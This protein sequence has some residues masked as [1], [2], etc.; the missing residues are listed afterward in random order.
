MGSAIWSMQEGATLVIVREIVPESLLKTMVEQHIE[1]ALLVPAVMLYLCEL[2]QSKTADFSALK[3]ITYGTAPISAEVLRRSI[4]TFKCR[5][6][7]LYGL[8]ETTGPFA[9]LTHEHH[10]AEKLASCGRPMFGAR[11]KV[12]DSSGKELPPYEVGEIVYQG[13]SLMVGYW[14]RQKETEEAIRDGWFHTGDAA[15]VDADGFLFIKDRIKDMIVSG[16]E[17]V[18]PAEVEAVLANHPEL[19]EVAVIGVPDAKWGE[20]VKACV[21]KRKDSALTAE[22]L[23]NWCRDKLAGYK[24]PRSIDFLDALPRNASGKMLKRKLREPYWVGYERKV[25]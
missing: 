2:P 16:S 23:I 9:A 4:D 14:A 21:V 5:F 7:Q 18:Y 20:S 3:H 24:R 13:E 1:T 17:N 19:V 8:T 25:N 22:G 10:V 6:S 12:V 15:Y 11:A